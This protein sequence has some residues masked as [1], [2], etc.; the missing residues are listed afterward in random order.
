M[1]ACDINIFYFFSY[2]HS[3][4]HSFIQSFFH[5]FFHLLPIWG[6][7][8]IRYIIWVVSPFSVTKRFCLKPLT[9]LGRFSWYFW[10]S[11]ETVTNPNYIRVWPIQNRMLWLVFWPIRGRIEAVDM[12]PIRKALLMAKVLASRLELE[13][14]GWDW[15]L[16]V[17]IGASRLRLQLQGWDWS[18]KAIIWAS[19]LELEPKG[20]D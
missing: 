9:H 3:F 4:T 7:I 20:Q 19:R 15:S 10:V 12:I 16:E 18:L 13:P 11:M 14:L 8:M 6:C 2:I 5:S 17:G 1:I